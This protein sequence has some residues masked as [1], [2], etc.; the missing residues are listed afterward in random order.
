MWY[1]VNASGDEFVRMRIRC[2]QHPVRACDALT[3]TSP[4]GFSVPTRELQTLN[5]LPEYIF[6]HLLY[7]FRLVILLISTSIFLEKLTFAMFSL[8]HMWQ[9]FKKIFCLWLHTKNLL[10]LALPSLIFCRLKIF[11]S[12]RHDK[13][14]IGKSEPPAKLVGLGRDFFQKLSLHNKKPH[15][16]FLITVRLF[17]FHQVFQIKNPHQRLQKCLGTAR[18]IKNLS[19][20]NEKLRTWKNLCFCGK[21]LK[22]AGDCV[23][24]ILGV[25]FPIV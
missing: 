13:L 6:K 14:F 24:I 18:L 1:T 8:P 7:G 5:S 19:A 4:G 23:K 22:N 12:P 11:I 21:L 20:L 25:G 17:D 3:C 10:S 9:W 16:V 15:C 2:S